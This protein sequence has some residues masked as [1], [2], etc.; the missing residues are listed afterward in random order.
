MTALKFVAGSNDTVEG[1]G[2]PFGGPFD[3]KDLDGEF[4]APDTDLCL[5]W[6]DQRPALY[7]HGT[8]PA[9][10][11]EVVG[12]VVHHEIRADGVWATTQLDRKHRYHAAITSLVE[13]GALGYSSGAM[14]H[15]VQ[16]DQ[17]SGKLTRWPWVEL[18]LT[19]T[20]ANPDAV[21]YR[22]KSAALA[23]E[24][25]G[26]IM[27]VPTPVEDLLRALDDGDATK[28]GL[29]HGPFA[30]HGQRVLAD[31][32]AFVGRTRERAVA[33]DKVG[34][35]LSTANRDLLTAHLEQLDSLAAAGDEI[36]RLLRE[37]D[38]EA[39]SAAALAELARFEAQGAGVLT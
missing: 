22:V 4:F 21:V 7:D 9:T 18:S 1:L 33:R 24:H 30:A 39:D 28:S 34:R 20:P 25:L 23:L 38:P 2:I 27:A 5:D 15:L 8:D 14:P 26:A 11:A 3:G 13:R 12:R 35:V 37:T 10:K 17:G 16:K 32:I 19:P 36:R 6:F 29:E 31:V